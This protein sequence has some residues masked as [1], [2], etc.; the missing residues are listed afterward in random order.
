MLVIV[1]KFRVIIFFN[2][3][4]DFVKTLT[5]LQNITQCKIRQLNNANKETQFEMTHY[6]TI[7]KKINSKKYNSVTL[8]LFGD[9]LW[10]PT[11]VTLFQDQ[12]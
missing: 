6:L 9:K 10:K 12:R 3:S 5:T 4:N 1:V 8:V 7:L 2:L 11:R